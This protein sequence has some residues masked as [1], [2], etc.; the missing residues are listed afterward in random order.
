MMKKER[1]SINLKKLFNYGYSEE[2]LKQLLS[3]LG[4]REEQ[5]FLFAEAEHLWKE[6]EK[7]KNQFTADQEKIFAQILAKIQQAENTKAT[8]SK[9][10][11]SFRKNYLNRTV[12]R[13]LLKIAAVFLVPVLLFAG[14]YFLMHHPRSNAEAYIRIEVPRGAKRLLVLPDST[15]VWINSECTLKYPVHFI[16]KT[17]TVYL[18][19]EAYFEVTK[20][21]AHP[22]I[23][24]T[25]EMNVR[26]LGTGFNVSAYPAA[27][28]VS[29]TLVHG[30]I[31]AYHVNAN[32]RIESKVILSP[33]ERSVFK[34]K[35][36]VFTVKK[37]DTRVYTSWKDGRLVFK[38]TPLSEIMKR[39]NRW[40]NVDM[41]A[42]DKTIEQFNYTVNFENDSLPAVLKVLEEMTPIRITLSGS[43]IF[44]T[45]DEK[46]WSD[47][48]KR[49]KYHN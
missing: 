13:R 44:V 23:V 38:D 47:F 41:T 33:G 7:H 12:F 22:F 11:I 37:V 4:S 25:P 49:R 29:A 20:D 45:R 46:R 10:K 36:N 15:K 34:M 40:Y 39:I 5:A 3:K 30:S 1:K 28:Q 43:R 21:A 32:G 6:S 27:K 18:V 31:L 9:R 2:E 42:N 8:T 35:K 26:V 16:G 19:G 17:R 48:M 14:G 24:S